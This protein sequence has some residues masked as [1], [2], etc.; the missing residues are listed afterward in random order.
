MFYNGVVVHNR[1]EIMGAMADILIETF[2]ME[3][4]VLRTQKLIA[5]NGEANAKIATAMT[6]VY[7]TDSFNKLEANS[8]KI[9][10]VRQGSSRGRSRSSCRWW[11]P[12]I[13]RSIA[14]HR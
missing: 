8:K 7:L 11:S 1:K 4:A 12:V 5:T 10:A 6:Q 14:G 13:L 2:A 9:V 3:S